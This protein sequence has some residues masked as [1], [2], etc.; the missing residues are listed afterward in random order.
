MHPI[1]ANDDP[2]FFGYRGSSLLPTTNSAYGA[3]P[4]KKVLHRKPCSQLGPGCYSGVHENR[5]Q[6]PTARSIRFPHT[7]SR[8]GRSSQSERAKVKV[9]RCDRRTAGPH[10][11]V[12]NPPS[13]QPSYPGLMDVV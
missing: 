6:D 1:G 11:F 5:I 4:A 12:E 10:H 2:C 13:L 3:L 9:E 8:R 7:V